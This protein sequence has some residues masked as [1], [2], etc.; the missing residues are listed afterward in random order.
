MVSSSGGIPYPFLDPADGGYGTVGLY[1]V[2]IL[3]VG[4]VVCAAVALAGS[5]MRT[6][7]MVAAAV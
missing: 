1:V 4:I 5:A 2:G 7:R 6:R 3:G